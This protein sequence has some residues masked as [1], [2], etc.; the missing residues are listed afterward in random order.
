MQGYV[1]VLQ[2]IADLQ[3]LCGFVAI[4]YPA[5]DVLVS[6]MRDLRLAIDTFELA[7]SLF[8]DDVLVRESIVL[9]Q[10]TELLAL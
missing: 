10:R 3:L 4:R 8:P 7:R 2:L 5:R 1:V 9:L 6:C